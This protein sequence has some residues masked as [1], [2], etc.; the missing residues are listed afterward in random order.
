MYLIYPS[1]IG[2]LLIALLSFATFI[3]RFLLYPLFF[4]P[5][6]KIPTA[7]PTSAFCSA[8]ITW[9]RYQRRENETLQAVHERKGPVVRL[10][11]G[12]LSVNCVRD[13]IQTIYGRGFEKHSWYRSF[14]NFGYAI[15][16]SKPSS[17]Y[18]RRVKAED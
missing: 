13:G 5:L 6:S 10:G 7:H 1:A 9:V 17:P 4:S 8:W 3:Y 16:S 18:R 15:P 12:E 2:G 14:E 11:P